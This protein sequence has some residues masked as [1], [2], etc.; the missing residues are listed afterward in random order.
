LTEDGEKIFSKIG[1][2]IMMKIQI[3]G[4]GNG[5]QVF[6]LIQDH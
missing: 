1:S 5:E 6:E 4:I 2:W 3:S